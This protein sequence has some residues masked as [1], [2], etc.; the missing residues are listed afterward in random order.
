MVIYLFDFWNKKSTWLNMIISQTFSV[1]VWTLELILKYFNE[2]SQAKEICVFLKITSIEKDKVK[3]KNR[4]GYTASCLRSE[5]YEAK[6]H[7][8]VY[9]SEN[10]SPCQCKKMINGQSQIDILK[11][12]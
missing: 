8:C 5:N 12:S 4:A 7:K 3:D 2:E 11:K 6:S 1:N 9:F 10:H